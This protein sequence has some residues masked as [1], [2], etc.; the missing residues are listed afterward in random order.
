[1]PFELDSQH[2]KYFKTK[3]IRWGQSNFADFPWRNPHKK[4]YCLVAEIMLQRT[5]AEQVVPVYR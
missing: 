5:K 4:W 1:M 3:L 2:T